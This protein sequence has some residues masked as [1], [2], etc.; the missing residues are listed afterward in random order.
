M[1]TSSLWAQSP[2]TGG[3]EVSDLLRR[4]PSGAS[5]SNAVPAPPRPAG[6]TR[7]P[8]PSP[9]RTTNAPRPEADSSSSADQI[10]NDVAAGAAP[11]PPKPE[12]AQGDEGVADLIGAR[13]ALDQAKQSAAAGRWSDAARLARQAKKWAPAS[14]EVLREAEEIESDCLRQRILTSSQIRARAALAAALTRADELLDAGRFTEGEDL[15]EGTLEACKLF[16]D[17]DTIAIYRSGAEDRIDRYRSSVRAGTIVPEPTSGRASVEPALAAT[18]VRVPENLPRL[19]RGSERSTPNWYGLTKDRLATAMTV[20]YRDKPITFVIDDIA[21]QSGV[22]FIIDEPTRRSRSV[23]NARLNL[24]AGDL[25][26][27]TLLNIACQKAGLE[28]VIMERGVVVTT[29]AR[30]LQYVRQMPEALRRN[31]AAARVLFPETNPEIFAANPPPVTT[32]GPAAPSVLDKAPTQLQNGAAL[33]D[34]VRR[35]LR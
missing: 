33:V 35:L 3:T 7:P 23:M 11:A 1:L 27:E 26:A 4:R 2:S 17:P 9:A 28:Y 21:G 16:P 34:H 10:V 24:R 31:W 20:D 22:P 29:P 12:S 13:K 30:A 6:S 14:T 5:K 25:P 15:L 32:P 19:L 8:A 18:A